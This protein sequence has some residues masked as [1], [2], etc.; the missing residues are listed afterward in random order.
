MA[1]TINN[2]ALRYTVPSQANLAEFYSEL[3]QDYDRSGYENLGDN[4]TFLL[5][6][7]TSNQ[8]IN[9]Q[10]GDDTIIISGNTSDT[11]YG[12]SGN[13]FIDGGQGNDTLRGGSGDDDILG[14]GGNDTI[15]GGS[16]NDFLAGDNDGVIYTQHGVDTIYGGT[17]NDTLY[18]G[19]QADILTGGTGADTFLYRVG[20]GGGNESRVGNADRITDFGAGDRIDVST[21]DADGNSAN[22]N[23]A[24]TFAAAASTTAGSYWIESRD[25]GQHVFF[26]VDGGTAAEMEVI[27]QTSVTLTDASFIL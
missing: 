4:D 17:G 10:G 21:M 7:A 2:L 3:T 12:G 25:D 15:N 24:F 22:G 9:A 13:D 11:V 16:G 1:L 8:F 6:T 14:S 20:F 18:G 23:S 19:G 5:R 27:V 26:N